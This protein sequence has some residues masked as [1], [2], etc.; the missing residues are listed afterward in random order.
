MTG[1]RNAS[2]NQ[3]GRHTYLQVWIGLNGNSYLAFY[4]QNSWAGAKNV[5]GA[6]AAINQRDISKLS[7]GARLS[8]SC[9]YDV[10]LGHSEFRC[11]FWHHNEA[12]C[13]ATAMAY[14]EREDEN[15]AI[16]HNMVVC[17]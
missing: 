12:S 16:N 8:R 13:P 5:F 2:V 9:V 6:P 11:I 1:K 14:S 4:H 10:D 17:I 7:L 15:R 3:G